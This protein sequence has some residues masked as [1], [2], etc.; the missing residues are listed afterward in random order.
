MR[1]TGYNASMKPHWTV[2]YRYASRRRTT[3]WR[4]FYI[5]QCS[6]EQMDYDIMQFNLGHYEHLALPIDEFPDRSTRIMVEKF[7]LENL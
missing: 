3:H 2:W 5:C 4:L 1:P 6:A 7:G